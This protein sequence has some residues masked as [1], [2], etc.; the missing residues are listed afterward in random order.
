MIS[1]EE[2]AY[3]PYANIGKF[4]MNSADYIESVLQEDIQRNASE[5]Q[6]FDLD[7]NRIPGWSFV[8]EL[9]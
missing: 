4:N 1:L 9:K 6:R 8:G 7:R 5:P 3:G 2:K